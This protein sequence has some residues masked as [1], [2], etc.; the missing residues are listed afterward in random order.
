[1]SAKLDR[2]RSIAAAV[3][4]VAVPLRIAAARAGPEDSNL[5]GRRFQTG[6]TLLEKSRHMPTC[7]TS[8]ERPPSNQ[9]ME[10]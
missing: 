5:H 3:R 2:E 7:S 4:M 1:M 6:D 10:E 8:G 9:T